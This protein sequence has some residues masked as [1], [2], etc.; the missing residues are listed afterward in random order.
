MSR[1]VIPVKGEARALAHLLHE[2]K[3]CELVRSQVLV[4]PQHHAC[5]AF[6]LARLGL[7][8][9]RGHVGLLIVGIREEGQQY[10]VQPD[11]GLDHVRHRHLARHYVLCVRVR[12]RVCV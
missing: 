12:W 1:F 7:V 6:G 4:Q 10:S 8:L 5:V 11:R 3:D 2:R 9:G